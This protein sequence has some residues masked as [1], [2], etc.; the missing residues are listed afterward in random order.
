MKRFLLKKQ[1]L[2]LLFSLIVYNLFSQTFVE[3]TGIALTGVGSSSVAWGDYDNDGDLDILLTG[4]TGSVPVSKIYRNN[5]GNSFDEQTGITL[6][7][8][9]AG[10][11]AWGDYD[12]DGDLDILLTGSNSSYQPVSKIYRNNGNNSFT[13]QTGITLIGVTGS[14]VAWGDYDN[15]GDLDI[16]LTGSLAT[17]RISKIYSNNGDNSFSE[18]TGITLMGVSGGSVAWGDCD[19]DGDL[20]ILLTGGSLNQ[21]FS[22]IYSNNGDNSFTEKTID[23]LT[24]VYASSVAWGDYDNDGDL[25]FLLTGYSASS[26]YFKIYRNLGNFNFSS[27]NIKTL[28]TTPYQSSAAWGDYNNDGRLDILLTGLYPPNSKISKIFRNSGGFTEQADIALTGVVLSSVAW[29]D[30]DN[31]GDLD[32]LLTGY[33]SSGAI[34]KIYRNETITPNVKPASPSNLLAVINNG[35]V[36]FTWDKPVDTETPQNGLSYNLYVYETGQSIYEYPPHAFKQADTNNG[37]RLV[38]KLGSVQWSPAG[39]TI[40]DLPPDKSYYWT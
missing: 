35:T 2:V 23:A 28:G 20:D 39:Y 17:G 3:Q 31:D 37:R 29:G 33:S 13:E 34:S 15:D 21:P 26:G 7:G 14:S 9:S 24:G 5:G 1:G 30:Y 4:W 12:N 27:L 40:K 38:A 6:M 16:L 11:V 25:D 19:N 32:I 22:K 36:N 18:Q 10:S 8:V